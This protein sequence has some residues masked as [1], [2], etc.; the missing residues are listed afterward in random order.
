MPLS[1]PDYWIHVIEQQDD[2]MRPS[3]I[4]VSSIFCIKNYWVYIQLPMGISLLPRI[5]LLVYP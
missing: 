1:E 4:S 2:S 3:S 5:D